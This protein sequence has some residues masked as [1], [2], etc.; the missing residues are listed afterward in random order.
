[1]GADKAA[2]R[3]A[4]RPVLARLAELLAGRVEEV[5][6][7]GRRVRQAELP[8][9]VSWHPDARPGCG[10]LGGIATALGIAAAE[11]PRPDLGDAGP[12]VLAV[13]CDM[14]LLAGEA[15]DLLLERRRP[16]R[17][18]TVPRNPATG[19]LEPL[20]AVYEHAA[21]GP[22]E[23]AID[24]GNLS[25]TALLKSIPIHELA[26]PPELSGQLANVNTPEDLQR[27]SQPPPP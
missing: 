15:V 17:L 25:A 8:R 14:P 9:C 12:A 23:R 18:A 26:L 3:V 19:R 10:P 20:A 11:P 6:I 24:T 1:M 27:L 2:M 22:I 5:W 7:V 21:L 13:A 4:G 16:D